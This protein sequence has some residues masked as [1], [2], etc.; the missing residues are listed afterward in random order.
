M[1]DSQE[2]FGM[3]AAAIEAG[4]ARW[5]AAEILQQPMLWREIGAALDAGR[6]ALQGFL[7]PLLN[8]PQLRIV[9]SGAGTSSYVGQCLAPVLTRALARRVEA[10]ATTDL[11]PSPG[12]YLAADTPTLLV[13]FARSGNSPESTAAVQVVQAHVQRCAHLVITCNEEGVLNLQARRLANAHAI[14]LPDATNDRSFAMTSSFSGMLLAAAHAFGVAGEAEIAALAERTEAFL[15]ACRPL[16][17][18]L[19][20]ARFQRVVYLGSGALKGFAREAALKMLELTDGRV[21]ATA[22]S[23]LG[24]RHGPKTILNAHTLVVAFLCNDPHV[25]RYDQDLVN[26]LNREAVAGRV[27]TVADVPGAA[28]PP[29]SL[30]LPAR[31]GGPA[32]ELALCMAFAPFAQSL[33]MLQSLALGICPDTP[34]AA[35]TVS[36]VVQGVTIYPWPGTA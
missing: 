22:D 27:I 31:A 35:G 2:A 6:T 26:E 17:G 19:V 23:T 36:R 4:G 18:E 13:S 20:R 33:A 3:S 11:V 21:I 8:L 15:P 29:G 30:V 16:L 9:L 1:A 14:V 12:S 7:A 28:Q 32:S 34:N 24:F 10:I 5:T 25:R